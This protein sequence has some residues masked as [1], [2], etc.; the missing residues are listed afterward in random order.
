MSVWAVA[1]LW[2]HWGDGVGHWGVQGF[3]QTRGCQH[4]HWARGR[5]S[6]NQCWRL[7]CTHGQSWW[8]GLLYHQDYPGCRPIVTFSVLPPPGASIVGINC[9]F[10]PFTCLEG[11]RRMKAGLDAAGLKVHLM[12]QP[13][14]FH[15]PDASRQGF[16]DLPEFPFALEPRIC[17][18]WDMHRYAREAYEIG[19]RYI[20]GCCGYEP[21]HIRAVA[22]EL[23][24]ERGRLPKGSEKHDQWGLGLRMHTKPWVRARAERKYWENLKPASGRPFCPSMSKAD[25][26][27]VTAV[28]MSS[29]LLVTWCT[30]TFYLLPSG[31]H[32][33]LAAERSYHWCWPEE[34]DRPQ[35][36]L[37]T[38]SHTYSLHHTSVCI[39]SKFVWTCPVWKWVY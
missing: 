19:I 34:T 38:S 4:V 1:V 16:I 39:S 20:G 6:W 35:R 27:G 26:W 37:R 17:T 5:P 7:C 36:G 29:I 32:W 31:K 9:H 14:A 23:A 10:D 30:L 33:A 21:Y 18:R 15:T 13:L 24:K 3:W 8:V 2:A 28:S 25:A 12:V 22:E 11:M